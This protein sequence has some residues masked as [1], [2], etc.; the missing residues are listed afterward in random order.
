MDVVE[1]DPEMVSVAEKWFG[2]VQGNRMRVFIEDGL[3][4][5]KEAKTQGVTA[6]Y[7]RLSSLSRDRD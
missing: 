1:V 6:V 3:L 5:V 4:F 7:Q 2:F